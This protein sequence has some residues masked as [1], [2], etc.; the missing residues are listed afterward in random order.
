MVLAKESLWIRE[1]KK[2]KALLEAQQHEKQ[3]EKARARN[4]NR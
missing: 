4:G 3:S 1:D 2:E